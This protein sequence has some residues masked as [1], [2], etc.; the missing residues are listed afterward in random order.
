MCSGYD[1]PGSDDSDYELWT[2][3]GKLSP[4]CLLGRKVTYIRRKRLAKC[5]NG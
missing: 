5:F 2:P 1:V 3:N 4:D